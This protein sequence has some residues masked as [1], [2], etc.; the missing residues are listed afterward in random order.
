MAG[1]ESDHAWWAEISMPSCPT[2]AVVTA[3]RFVRD[4][5]RINRTVGDFS[6]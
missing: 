2:D 5:L 1:K 6:N 4:Q 3:L